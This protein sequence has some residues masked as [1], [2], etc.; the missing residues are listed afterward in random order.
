M[1]LEID[2]VS[3]SPRGRG[4]GQLL[5]ERALHAG[6]AV[7]VDIG[8]ADDVGGKAGLRIKPV[9]LAIDRQAGLAQRVDRLDQFRRRRGGADS[10]SPCPDCSMA[11]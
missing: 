6:D 7:A 5:V 4:V 2:R 9:G 8:V 10:R 3:G 1:R 11:K